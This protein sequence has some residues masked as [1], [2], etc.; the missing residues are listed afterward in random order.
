VG[1]EY[2][3]ANLLIRNELAIPCALP[4][5]TRIKREV[6]PLHPLHF[7]KAFVT[8]QQPRLP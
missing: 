7:Q 6:N 4:M 5:W 3:W 1:S 2:K 8:P